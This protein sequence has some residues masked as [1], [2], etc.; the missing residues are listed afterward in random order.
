MTRNQAMV[1]D[2]GARFSRGRMDKYVFYGMMSTMLRLHYTSYAAV[3]RAS[4]V[5]ESVVRMRV[6]D[7]RHMMSEGTY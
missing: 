5:A 3:A 7:I 6:R 1:T 2:A 4:N